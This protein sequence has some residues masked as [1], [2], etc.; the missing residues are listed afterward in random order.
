MLLDL[1]NVGNF[2]GSMPV[3][4]E[5]I[6][7]TTSLALALLATTS[8]APNHIVRRLHIFYIIAM[9]YFI[10]LNFQLVTITLFLAGHTILFEL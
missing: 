1:K 2:N 6:L 4:P 3:W 10:V 8:S 9:F 5:T 7:G